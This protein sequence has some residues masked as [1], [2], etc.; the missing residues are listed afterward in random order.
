MIFSVLA[1]GS[2]GNSTYINTYSHKILV[3]V[4]TNI[5]NIEAKLNEIST[6]LD[7]I[8]YI[9]I[10]HTHSDH[11]SSLK[12]IIR[13]YHPFVVLTDLMLADLDY[14]SNY[15]K[16]IIYNQ[17]LKIDDVLVEFIKT[18]HDV[19]DSRGFIFSKDNH[20]IVY[21]TDTGYINSKYFN[22]LKNKN[23]YIFES[24]HDVEKLINGKYPKWLQNRILSDVGHLSNKASAFYLTKF[25]GNDTKN[26]IL[27]HLSKENNSDE[28]ALDTLFKTFNEYDIDFKNVI[29]A[30]Q[31]IQTGLIEI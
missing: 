18:S 17:D 29:I 3:D 24:N 25:I 4:G 31:D 11:T 2:S 1:S 28:L 8:E 22:K 6:S 10:S 12:Q 21:I 15:D 9:F 20:S 27:A 19:T 13:H 23:A 16:L 7:E 14:L 26:V 5:K 30:H